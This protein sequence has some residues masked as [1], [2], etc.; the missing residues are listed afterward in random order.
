MELAFWAGLAVAKG[1]IIGWTHADMQT[2]PR[3]VLAAIAL[4][5]KH[6]NHIYAKGRRFGRPLSDSFF[7]VGMSIFE[8]LSSPP[9][10]GHQ[11]PAKFISQNFYES[12]RIPPEDFA[13]DLFVYAQA[14]AAGSEYM[15]V[16]R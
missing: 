11:C 4:F 3:D 12:W 13:L 1:D 16:S 5:E 2:D 7:T 9:S 14:R 10:L 15:P 6:G 8:S